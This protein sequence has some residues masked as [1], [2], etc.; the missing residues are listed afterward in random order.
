LFDKDYLIILSARQDTGVAI[1]LARILLETG[2]A[3]WVNILPG[4]RSDGHHP[5]LQWLADPK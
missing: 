4:L 3:V 1:G 5:C 2:L